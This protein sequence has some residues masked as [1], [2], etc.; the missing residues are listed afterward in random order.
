MN[1]PDPPADEWLTP[2]Q[3]AALIGVTADTVRKW[4]ND[5]ILPSQRT[6]P[7]GHRRFLR[8]DVDALVS[9]GA[10]AEPASAAS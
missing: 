4:A 5:G 6:R 1:T 7:G 9:S 2:R 8:S 3:A 10:A